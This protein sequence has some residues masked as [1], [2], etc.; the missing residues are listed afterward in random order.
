MDGFRAPDH[1]TFIDGAVFDAHSPTAYLDGF[2]IGLKGR[3]T[4][5]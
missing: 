3:A 1:T 5:E 4:V 2:V